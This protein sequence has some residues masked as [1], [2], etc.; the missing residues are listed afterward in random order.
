[1]V[2]FMNNHSEFQIALVQNFY[3]PFWKGLKYLQYNEDVVPPLNSG[4][5]KV[6]M[7]KAQLDM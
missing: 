1:M 7:A 5:Y 6:L 3:I 4:L 2:F